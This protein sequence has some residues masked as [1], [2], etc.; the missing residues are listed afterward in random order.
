M[1]RRDEYAI[2]SAFVR[3]LELM[4]PELLYTISPAGFIIARVRIS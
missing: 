2:Q 4:Y 3:Y 1:A